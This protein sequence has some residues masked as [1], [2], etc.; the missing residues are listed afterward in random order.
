MKKLACLGMA[1][2]AWTLVCGDA[3]GE[4]LSFNVPAPG[5]DTLALNGTAT[6]SPSLTYDAPFP[7]SD[8]G[9]IYYF[10][11][12]GLDLSKPA[13]LLVFMHGGNRRSPDTSPEKYLDL[14]T[15]TMMPTLYDAPFIVA[16]PSA[17]PAA[18]DAPKKNSR[19]CQ[20]D[21]VKYIEATI[22]A[23]C[24]KFKIDRD[25]VFLG[26][27]SM[28]GFGAYHLAQLMADRL[29]G[30][31]LSAG[32]WYQADFRSMLGTPIF[33][34]HGKSDC[35][36][37]KKYIIGTR[38][39]P[40]PHGWTGVS[41]ARAADALMTRYG[42]EH[43]YAEHA[44]GHAIDSDG[45]KEATRK[46]MEWTKDKR[47]APYARKTALVTPVG[48]WHPGAEP[49]TKARW[50]ELLEETGGSISVDA[51]E[52]SGPAVANVP[53]D[54]E[55]QTYAV[56]PRTVAHGAR[57]VAENLGG[58]RFKV[59]TENVRRFAIL[60]APPMGDL[61]K[62]FTVE[63]GGKART[64]QAEA[65]SGE[66]DY[67]ARLVV[68]VAAP[69]ATSA[70]Y[71]PVENSGGRAFRYWAEHALDEVDTKSEH[72]VVVV[73]G[74]N[75]GMRDGTG[76][77]RQ[78]L[79]AAGRD[80]SK[81]YFVGPN[82]VVP[83]L[84][85]PADKKKLVVSMTAEEMKKVVYW[86]AGTWQGGGDSPVAKGF[87]SYDALDRI[88]EKLNDKRL[89][90]ALKTVLICG[91][92][93]GGQ[94]VSRYV[95]LS[96]IKPREG[97]QLSFAAGAPS[98]WFRYFD[99]DT[100]WIYG[101]KDRNRYAAKVTE[102][103]IMENLSSRWCLCFC[104]TKDVLPRWLDVHDEANAQGPNRFE[105]FKNFR[106]YVATFPQLKDHFR[107][108]MLEGKPHGGMC[109]ENEP[110]FDLVFGKR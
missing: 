54:L 68:D 94:V 55:K 33:I 46:F 75:G 105:R 88:F 108:V 81:V 15:G 1:A 49:V 77:V 67:T 82:I 45:A 109:Y 110:F 7:G 98:T 101:L 69:P 103:Q 63:V 90:P 40:R 13:P 71:L 42:V 27:H 26:G 57:I 23:A 85:D 12:K 74:V 51:I 107:F 95:A 9:R 21:G 78:L 28:G 34:M 66:P 30:A 38:G 14:K 70:Y 41:F 8:T 48:S 56:A 16:A 20:P 87:S 59:A 61:S 84:H 100:R 92:S 17:P 35:S 60:L 89:F 6:E 24:G 22:D 96:P 93:A 83:K 52:L 97:L 50:L 5:A 3:H 106:D 91:Y 19:W 80:T 4:T 62:P 25:R 39:R 11:P 86:K 18:A 10:V 73:H 37:E 72:A 47:R 36:P 29:A 43:V 99:E 79:R 32:A 104:G 76:R 58:N 2:A 53:A 102:E 65:L 64:V 31:W 44:D